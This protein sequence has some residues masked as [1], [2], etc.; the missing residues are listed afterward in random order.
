[1]PSAT[2][3][4]LNFYFD[5]I[6]IGEKSLWGIQLSA[7]S[8]SPQINTKQLFPAAGSEAGKSL[9][10]ID[11]Q[12]PQPWSRTRSEAGATQ[13]GSRGPRRGA[14]DIGTEDPSERRA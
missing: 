4:Q 7:L 11:T 13:L 10:R 5:F 14:Q 6:K 1:M 3:S 8:L 12:P 2:E 9:L